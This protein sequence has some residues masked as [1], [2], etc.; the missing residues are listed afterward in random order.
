MQAAEQPNHV[1]MFVAPLHIN[2]GSTRT[3]S[4]NS[5]RSSMSPTRHQRNVAAQSSGQITPP[6]TPYDTEQNMFLPRDDFGGSDFHTYLRAF[7][8]YHP[9]GDDSS[10]TVTLPLNSGD[11]ILVHSVHTNGW[12]DGTLL[13][14]GARGW[15]PTNYCEPYDG[16]PICIL[17]KALTSFWDLVRGS[18]NG[19]LEVFGRQDYVRGLIAGVRYL[20]E[21]AGCLNRESSIV[22]SHTGLRRNRKALLSD[23]S[24]FVK[25][26]KCFEAATKD[27][28]SSQ[29]SELDLDEMVL[30]AFKMVNRGVKFLDIWKEDIATLESNDEMDRLKEIT[31]V[32]PTPPAER[33]EFGS[34]EKGQMHDN[35][36][37]AS[38]VTYQDALANNDDARSCLEQTRV[39][40]R[41]SRSSQTYMRPGSLGSQTHRSLSAQGPRLSISHRVS[42]IGYPVAS[43]NPN[44]ASEKL[45]VAHDTF[46][47][48]LG[49]FIGLHLQ[50]RSSSELLLTTQQ[51]VTSCRDMLRVVEEIWERDSKRSEL[52][53]EARDGMYNKITDLVGVARDVFRPTRS[54]GEDDVLLP[55]ES[56]PLVDAATACVR[57]AGD[58]VAESR[59]VIERIGDFEFEPLG[60]GIIDFENGSAATRGGPLV[61]VEPQ[62]LSP[63]STELPVPV[64]PSNKPP[65]PPRDDGD[66]QTMLT[67]PAFPTRSTWPSKSMTQGPNTNLNR[68]S[69]QSLL[70]PLVTLSGPLLSPDEYPLSPQI[71]LTI[72]CDVDREQIKRP[73]AD[74][75]DVSSSGASSTY[76]GSMRDSET[77]VVS[78]A[79]T[80]ATSPDSTP[81]PESGIS[82]LNASF[83]GSQITLNDDCEEAEVKILE[84]TYAHELVYN[85]EAQVSGGTLPALIERLT[86]HDST[87]DATFVST[88]YLTFRMF[89]TPAQFAEALIDRFHYVGESPRIAGPV[90][91]R[92]YN[93]F[94]GWLESHWR[95]DCDNEAL[96]LILPFATRQLLLVLP[97][98]GKRLAS[99]A[100]K[101]SASSGPL[102]PRLI[103][104]MGKTNTS[105]APYVSPD[106]PLPTPIV[107]KNNISAL[108]NWKH[109]GANVSILDFDPLEL[110]RQFTI[111]ES[112]IFCAILPEEL[113]AE[114]WTKQSGSMAVNVRAM[115]RLSTDLAN[116]VA[117]CILQLED[118]K[119]RAAVIKQWVKIA[120]KF[121]EL[122]NYDSLMAIICSLNSSTILRLKRTWELVS[123]KTKALLEQLKNV[124]D[125]SRNCAVLRQRLQNHIPPCLPFVGMYLTDLTF[126]D[127]GNQTTRQ[128]QGDGIEASKPVINFDKH[129]KIAKIISDLQRFQIPY[130][131]AEVPELQ[132]WIQDQLVRVRSSDESNVQSYYRRSLL[133][134]PREPLP[135]STRPSPIES[136]A[137][138]FSA[139]SRE[140]FELFGLGWSHLLREKGAITPS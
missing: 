4:R 41:Y 94:K 84:K 123:S 85:K 101:V 57:G 40:S 2:K 17:L 137:P 99:L 10:S 7:Y 90:R 58:C 95:N 103:S 29:L 47:G 71:S 139:S 60:L 28:Q 120:N 13:V 130:R 83:S 64:E 125:V 73:R 105:I 18:A 25:M 121:L 38:T 116:L 44:L 45:S 59:F 74:S 49:S 50:S 6:L 56:K 81:V 109:G 30:K 136:Q 23:L 19:R 66:A 37:L 54:G 8:P 108:R 97:T 1:S 14:S 114:E 88:F 39:R 55:S 26:A 87:P 63:G 51:S 129:M 5:K 112:R 92:V 77:S 69:A 80:R 138:S 104:S 16:E 24:A 132:T 67:V 75:L 36:E 115:S 79:S 119:K 113:L 20:L 11:I 111:K 117:D 72:E 70:P 96:Q 3:H 140:K 33:T 89:A 128:L 135:S 34:N 35:P 78:Q 48:F 65:P 100:E 93:V 91:L 68:S 27:T 133:L 127:A 126:A 15:L 98:A 76:I 107:T 62:Q 122:A 22:Q 134:E 131:F 43:P 21:K 9:S 82:S 86:T 46:L 12:A 32:P 124:V 110:A 53:E 118:P 52:L 106:T 61:H 31:N 102:V 42:C